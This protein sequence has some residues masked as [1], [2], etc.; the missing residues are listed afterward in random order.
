MHQGEVL[1][2]TLVYFSAF[3]NVENFKSRDIILTEDFPG[4]ALKLNRTNACISLCLRVFTKFVFDYFNLINSWWP[5]RVMIR[6]QRLRC[7]RCFFCN[8]ATRRLGDTSAPLRVRAPCVA[9]VGTRSA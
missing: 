7:D 1:M 5:V 2:Y 9:A 4:I 3:H 8:D 6:L